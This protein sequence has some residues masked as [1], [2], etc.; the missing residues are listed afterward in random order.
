MAESTAVAVTAPFGPMGSNGA[1][2]AVAACA[3]TRTNNE[4]RSVSSV[5]KAAN[6]RERC[7]FASLGDVGVSVSTACGIELAP[8]KDLISAE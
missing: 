5:P 4:A 7:P 2:A 8:T 3:G 6:L 1:D